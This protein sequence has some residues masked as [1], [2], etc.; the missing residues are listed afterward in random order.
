MV[1]RIHLGSRSVEGVARVTNIV[2]GEIR[3]VIFVSLPF[4]FLRLALPS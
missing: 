4:S 1:V 2:L 3:L